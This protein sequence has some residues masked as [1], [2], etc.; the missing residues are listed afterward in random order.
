[1]SPIMVVWV[2][3]FHEQWQYF[4]SGE[5]GRGENWAWGEFLPCS[6]PIPTIHSPPPSLSHCSRDVGHIF[7]RQW[8]LIKKPLF[9]EAPT[10]KTTTSKNNLVLVKDERQRQGQRR[11]L[12][13][14][15]ITTDCGE[16]AILIPKH[17]YCK[18]IKERN[19]NSIKLKTNC[20]ITPCQPQQIQLLISQPFRSNLRDT[21]C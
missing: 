7:P 21:T 18:C 11:G 5:V 8:Q 1:M 2:Y 3:N 17:T 4:Q 20:L 10:G 6:R 15:N 9:R 14:I 12:D 13:C 19:F 16:L